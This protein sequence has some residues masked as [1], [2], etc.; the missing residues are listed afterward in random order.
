[1]DSITI[2]DSKNYNVP[3]GTYTAKFTDL[4]K[5]PTSRGQAWKW[6][7]EIDEGELAKTKV[8]ELSD[9]D[10]R[11]TTANK[12]GRFLMALTSKSLKD[13]DTINPAEYIGRRYLL[14]V[15]PKGSDKTQIATF[16][17]LA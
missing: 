16:S 8:S 15:S 7:F 10:S 5:I 14:V 11:A 3:C 13:G 17:S 12:T 4:E 6:K 1:M 9:A 2:F